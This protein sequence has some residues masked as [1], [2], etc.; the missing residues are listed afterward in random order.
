MRELER[1]VLSLVWSALVLCKDLSELK[2]FKETV[3]CICK[4]RTKASR[5]REIER[6]F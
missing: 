3:E 6:R 5:E 1:V 2:E 4:I